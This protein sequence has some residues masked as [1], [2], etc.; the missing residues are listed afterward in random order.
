MNVKKST[1]LL[2]II[3][4]SAA[5]VLPVSADLEIGDAQVFYTLDYGGLLVKVEG[6]AI[7]WPGDEINITVRVQASAKIHIDF[8]NLNVSSLEMNREEVP[9]LGTVSFLNNVD[10][11]PEAI[12]QT[13]YEVEVPNDALPGLIYGMIWYSWH[14]KGSVPD[15]HVMLPKAFPATFIENKPYIELKEDF[16][17][18]NSSYRNL[19]NSYTSLDANYTD[20]QERFQ[21]LESAQIG[22]SNATGLMYLFLIT[23][24]IFVATTLILMIRRPKAATW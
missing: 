8:V 3:L 9:L 4:F 13:S 23:T 22:E 12:N 10:L 15:P 6:P 20:L 19:Q 1:Y 14:I 5:A 11:N 7:A 18:L 17:D 21:Q 2:M 24:G 16:D